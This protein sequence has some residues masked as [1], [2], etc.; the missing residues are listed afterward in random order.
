MKRI[1]IIIALV[2]A[3]AF[4]A[5]AQLRVEAGV[6]T[7][8]YKVSIDS[9]HTA[10]VTPVLKAMYEFGTFGEGGFDAGVEFRMHKITN[11]SE[12]RKLSISNLDIPFHAYYNLNFGNLMITPYVGFYA[13]F[14][15]GGKTTVASIE[16]SPFDGPQGMKKFDFGFDS[17]IVITLKRHLTFGI[18]LQNGFL[19]LSKDK[20]FNCKS[21]AAYAA[22]GWRF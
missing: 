18:G 9:E 15:V 2:A 16:T 7:G 21:N 22:V 1:F 20:N 13:G 12:S 17:E 3:S 19:N 5:K 10:N 14:A 8:N 6:G 4:S 11:K